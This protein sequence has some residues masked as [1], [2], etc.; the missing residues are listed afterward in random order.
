MLIVHTFNLLINYPLNRK[1][2]DSKTLN[3]IGRILFAIPFAGFAL[4]HFM[5]GD[6]MAGMVPTWLP[7]GVFWVYL[8][9]VAMLAGA[10]S[11]VSGQMGLYGSLGIAA[12]MLVYV[13]TIYVPMWMSENP[14][15]SQMGQMG[16]FKDTGL[17]G[18]ALGYAAYFANKG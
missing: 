18:G 13:A 12:L 8:T 3:L 9:G 7:G 10:I 1:D 4:G 14:G 16:A 17:A 6:M 5:K 15:A 11:M 2:M